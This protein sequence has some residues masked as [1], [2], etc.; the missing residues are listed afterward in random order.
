MRRLQAFILLFVFSTTLFANNA[1]LH[2]CHGELTDIALFGDT[3]CVCPDEVDV[4]E[5]E[6]EEK[7]T[8]CPMS[9]VDVT[10]NHCNS[11]QLE[12]DDD[13]CETKTVIAESID[14]ANSNSTEQQISTL[15]IPLLQNNF[16]TFLL[17]DDQV[18]ST[19]YAP[20]LLQRDIIIMVQSFLI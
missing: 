14:V 10:T 9:Q 7:G 18:K 6:L 16:Y 20:P 13:C 11:P 4:Q 17:E 1:E 19:L 5:T 8:C 2:Y 12:L 15:I 3:H